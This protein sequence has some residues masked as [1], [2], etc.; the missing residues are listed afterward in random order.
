MH[1]KLVLSIQILEICVLL[2]EDCGAELLKLTAEGVLKHVDV[3]NT[4]RIAL[5]CSGA[6]IND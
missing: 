2:F 5:A 4:L 1:F 3:K 6:D